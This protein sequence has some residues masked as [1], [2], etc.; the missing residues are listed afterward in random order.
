VHRAATLQRPDC[1]LHFEVTGEG[2]AIVFAHGLGGSHL[3]WWQ[4]VPHFAPRHTCVAFSHRGFAPSSAPPGG[5][6]PRDFADDLEALLD[7]LAL[8]RPVLVAQSM[9]GWGAVEFALRHPG[10]LRGLVLAATTGSLDPGRIEDSAL[11]RRLQAWAADAR[12]RTADALAAGIHPAV[13]VRMAAE[14]PAHAH[15][16]RAIDAMSEGL[17]KPALRER[18]YAMRTRRP[19]ELAGAY[20]PVLFVA[21]DED[22]VL[23]PFAADAIAPML[24]QARVVRFPDAGHSAYFERPDA[25]NLAVSAF[26]DGLAR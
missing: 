1:R 9:G 15:L 21:G 3:S 17:D 24:P 19:E 5:P 22:I 26:I 6:D 16:Y 14:Q 2:P 4:Q 12:D 13:G 10:R 11:Q 23:P 18:L 25:F 20:C 8:E 7:L